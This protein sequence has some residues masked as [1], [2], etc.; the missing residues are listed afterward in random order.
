MQT[1]LITEGWNDPRFTILE[2]KRIIPFVKSIVA[3]IVEAKLTPDQI[4]QLFTSVEQGAT[5]AGSNR[6]GIGKAVDVAKLPVEAVKFIDKKINDLGRAIQNTSPVKNLDQKFEQLK[7]KIG[8]KDSKVV[9]GIQ[10]VSDWAKANPNDPRSTKI[11]QR[12][13]EQ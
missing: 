9:Q 4:S 7:A 8:A 12:L 13:G 10:A 3:Y 5:A 11:K 1:K 2:Q 6:S